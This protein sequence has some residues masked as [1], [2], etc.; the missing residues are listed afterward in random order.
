MA[1]NRFLPRAAGRVERRSG[2]PRRAE[3]H[4]RTAGD[5]A[6]LGQSPGL[7]G[8]VVQAQDRHR[9]AEGPVGERQRL[10]G[11]ADA[12]RRVGRTLRRHDQRGLDR[13][14]PAVARL[15][16]AGARAHVHH[17]G[18]RAERAGDPDRDPAIRPPAYRPPIRS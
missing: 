1:K 15:V 10:R 3:Q 14:H 5:P 16:R 2:V 9:G 4:H 12:R 13:D 17:A 18:R 6:Q 11:R 7:V 8:P